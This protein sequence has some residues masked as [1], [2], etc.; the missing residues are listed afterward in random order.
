MLYN[1]LRVLY[2]IY[3]RINVPYTDKPKYCTRKGDITTN[4]LRVC[5]QDMKFICLVRLGRL[6]C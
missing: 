1:C 6:S 5:S 4:V 3:I 2:G